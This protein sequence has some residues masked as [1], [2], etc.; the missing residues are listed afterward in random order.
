MMDFISCS[1]LHFA[2]LTQF[3]KIYAASMKSRSDRRD[4]LALGTVSGTPWVR[5]F[6]C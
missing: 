6:P 3:G 5:C 1:Y 2:D 4:A